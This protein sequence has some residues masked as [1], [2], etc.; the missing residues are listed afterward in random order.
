MVRCA[1][2]LILTIGL[3]SVGLARS[4]DFS[5][6][7]EV[8]EA[9]AARR[10]GPYL[11]ADLGFDGLLARWRETQLRRPGDDVSAG[12]A[13]GGRIGIEV[14]PGAAVFVDARARAPLSFPV[15]GLYMAEA[16][17]GGT[18][19]LG[20]NSDW[21]ADLVLRHGWAHEAAPCCLS[22][23]AINSFNHIWTGEVGFGAIDRRGQVDRGW[24]FSL[25]GGII[26]SDGVSG[27]M[28]GL[29]VV[30]TWSRS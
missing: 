22:P 28:M 11:S 26:R 6:P 4:R 29:G 25:L 7:P 12:F 13:V 1:I 27:W 10:V 30:H 3:Q 21:R 15:F 8:H 23:P 18:T 20:A 19:F 16:G 5:A 17:I 14:V 24:T 9:A 2:G